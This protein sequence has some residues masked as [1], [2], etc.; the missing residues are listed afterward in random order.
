MH[1]TQVVTKFHVFSN[2][3]SRPRNH[4]RAAKKPR[5]PVELSTKLSSANPIAKTVG[6]LAPAKI[7]VAKVN[8]SAS[9]KAA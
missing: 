2:Q 9:L 7:Q 4:P 6:Y 1:G 8:A 3:K 5:L